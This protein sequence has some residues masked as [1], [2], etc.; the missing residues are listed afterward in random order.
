VHNASGSKLDAQATQ[1]RWVGYDADSTHAHHIYWPGKNSISV[2][3]NI[4]FVPPTIAINTSP[5]SYA[6]TMG[7]ASPPSAPSSPTVQP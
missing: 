6:S 5:P 2:E 4:K 3:W 7:P 1:A